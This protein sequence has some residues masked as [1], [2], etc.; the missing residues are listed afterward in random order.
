MSY[1]N[2]TTIKSVTK[3]NKSTIEF[4]LLLETHENGFKLIKLKEW[5]KVTKIVVSK[6]ENLSLVFSLTGSDSTWP[7][8]D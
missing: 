6:I 1:H 8:H 2:I 3:T 5:Y 4:N 7:E